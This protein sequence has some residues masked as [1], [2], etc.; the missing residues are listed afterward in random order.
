[1]SGIR[2]PGRA[3]ASDAT[4]GGVV[5]TTPRAGL[6][7]GLLL[8]VGIAAALVAA[9][10]LKA[11]TDVVGPLFLAV[12]LSIVV[13]PVRGLSRRFRLPGWVGVI[14]SLVAVYLIVAG[15]VLIVVLCG[16]QLAALLD[17]SG[18]QFQAFAQ[19]VVDK[20]AGL[21][22]S[23]D[24]LEAVAKGLDPGKLIDFTVGL[25]GGLAGVLSSV[26][27]LVLLLF[28]TVSDAGKFASRLAEISPAGQRL[29]TAFQLFAHGSRR[30]LGVSTVFGAVV[31]LLD[32]IALVILDIRYAWLWAL[33]AFVTNFIPN[34]GFIIGL[35]PPTILA[36]LDHG[37]GTAIA[38]IV[39]YC[40]LNIVLQS[41]IQPRVV[42]IV[43]GLTGTLSFVSLVVWTS[44]LG[45]VGALLAVPATLLVKAL[46]VDVDPDRHWFE[47]LLSNSP[48][49][50]EPVPETA[51]TD[52]HAQPK[53][54]S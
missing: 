6:S 27:F 16:V 41:V 38:I 24:Q 12:V 29:A 18:P 8:I 19:S 14:L 35:V 43:V 52:A 25:L 1:M 21:G 28:F 13:H 30:Y 48:A 46:F 36:L 4:A 23:Q 42:G 11:F 26:S 3:E 44:I 2:V 9:L 31:A 32:F 15:L 20:L 5:A 49:T 22:V 17:E 37:A 39:I 10:G 45:A 53:T 47:P 33:L 7:R 34:V 40:V 50:D 51:E 54:P